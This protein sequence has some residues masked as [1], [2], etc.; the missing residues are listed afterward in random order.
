[1]IRINTIEKD[2][3]SCREY[4]QYSMSRQCVYVVIYAV[5]CY[6]PIVLEISNMPRIQSICMATAKKTAKV[7]KRYPDKHND[8]D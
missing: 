6:G 7:K 4:R 1:M 5:Q 3:V 8:Q 2:D